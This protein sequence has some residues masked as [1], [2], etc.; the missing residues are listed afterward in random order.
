MLVENALGLLGL[1]G[2]MGLS[3]DGMLVEKACLTHHS[4]SRQ[5]RNVLGNPHFVPDG[6]MHRGRIA[7]FYQ[8]CVPTGH[9]E[10]CC[11]LFILYP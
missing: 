5:G 3:R 10:N 9:R 7:C 4:P 8:H 1:L 11:R 2:L 6:T